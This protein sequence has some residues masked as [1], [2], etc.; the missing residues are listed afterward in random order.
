MGSVQPSEKG[1][2][3]HV[4]EADVSPQ[5]RMQKSSDSDLG[6]EEG[7]SDAP[8]LRDDQGEIGS[9]ADEFGKDAPLLEMYE[10]QLLRLM[11]SLYEDEGRRTLSRR[12]TSEFLIDLPQQRRDEVLVSAIAS[13]LK[14]EL[15][16][17]EKKDLAALLK[18]RD[19]LSV[20]QV[21]M[22]HVLSYRDGV[23]NKVHFGEFSIVTP[24]TTGDVD[25]LIA[26]MQK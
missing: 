26:V 20:L 5:L 21:A 10:P 4:R 7:L 1:N 14:C 15:Q 11:R 3:A 12:P 19:F 13:E 23:T 2:A 22:P 24:V 17:D 18:K 8:M 6:S 9:D 25:D 16:E